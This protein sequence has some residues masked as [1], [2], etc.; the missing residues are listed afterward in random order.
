ML[1]L[2][3]LWKLGAVFGKPW[4]PALQVFTRMT[5]GHPTGPGS[6]LTESVRIGYS[7]LAC[8]S[9]SAKYQSV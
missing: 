7:F 5:T 9:G 2:E 1:I 3:P 8:Q 6:M 4:M